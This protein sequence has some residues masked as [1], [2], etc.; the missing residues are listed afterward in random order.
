MQGLTEIEIRNMDNVMMVMNE[1]EKNRTVASTKMNTNR[2][3]R[4][5]Y[6]NCAMALQ[7]GG[8]NFPVSN[9]RCDNNLISL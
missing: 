8:C 4:H 6:N 5:M 9:L 2:Y 3:T 7:F 1:G